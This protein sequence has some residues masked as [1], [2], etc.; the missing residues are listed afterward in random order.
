[1]EKGEKL[2]NKFGI[3]DLKVWYNEDRWRDYL[4]KY[5]PEH[6]WATLGQ[7]YLNTFLT[8]E[9]PGE[10][11]ASNLN[12][13][14][15]R[16]ASF[17]PKSVLEVGCGFGRV[18]SFLVACEV[19]EEIKGVEL[20]E[21]MIAEMPRFVASIN[22]PLK[23]E[24]KIIQGD[25]TKGIDFPNQSFDVVYSHVCLT[26]IEPRYIDCVTKEISRI[27][28]KAIIHVERFKFPNE[29]PSPHRWSHDL[30][31]YYKKLGWVVFDYSEINIEHSTKCLVLV[32]KGEE[33]DQ[34]AYDGC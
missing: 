28:K 3:E 23:R 9:K 10:M 19:C 14:L 20:S 7:C 25:I 27:A 5:E 24:L 18:L 26:H 1:M 6:F 34:G 33:Y 21:S 31:Y 29:H 11:F 30:V 22:P 12:F 8:A 4:S 17:S 16:I 2:L 13:L 32:R 15:P